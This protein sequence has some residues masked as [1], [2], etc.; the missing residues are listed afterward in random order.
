MA[1]KSIA[2]RKQANQVPKRKVEEAETVERIRSGKVFL[3]PVDIIENPNEIILMADM[4]GTDEKSI[5]IT[6]EKNVLTIE[7]FVSPE[8]PQDL[9]LAYA[10]YDVGDYRRT[11]TLS[12]EINQAKIDASY[13]HGVLKIKLPKAEAAKPKKIKVMAA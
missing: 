5:D 3:P 9:N 12:N 6:L 4:P 7:G 2:I 11:F 8:I 1:E 10:E 13:K